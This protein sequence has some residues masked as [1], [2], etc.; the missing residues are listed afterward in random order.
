MR[1]WCNPSA[2]QGRNA[3]AS[4][5]LEHEKPATGRQTW[6]QGCQ[7]NPFLLFLC[8][9]LNPAAFN[10]QGRTK[11]SRV[12]NRK[13]CFKPFKVNQ[14]PNDTSRRRARTLHK[15]HPT[16]TESSGPTLL[17][18]FSLSGSLRFRFD[19]LFFESPSRL[20][21][22][23][24]SWEVRRSCV[25]GCCSTSNWSKQKEPEVKLWRPNF[26]N[27]FPNPY[28]CWELAQSTSEGW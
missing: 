12:I 27:R 23:A 20:W 2:T 4:Y 24:V 13:D 15:Y 28:S 22:A 18:S 21:L 11:L 19:W 1:S 17:C 14:R 5:R 16:A 25:S 9:A 6:A 3:R 10:R 8:S 26:A 7:E